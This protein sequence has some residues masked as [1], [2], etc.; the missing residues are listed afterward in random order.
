MF[1]YM[2]RSML[3]KPHTAF[4]FSFASFFDTVFFN[5]EAHVCYHDD[6]KFRRAKKI[7][8]ADK[9]VN[10]Y[11]WVVSSVIFCSATWLL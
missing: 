2:L 4:F 3:A 10:F 9:K 1:V 11:F 6:N 5:S 8:W 7:A